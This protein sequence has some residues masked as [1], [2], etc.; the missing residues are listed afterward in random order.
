[1]R[2]RTLVPATSTRARTK[3]LKA[4]K[5]L[6]WLHEKE[7]LYFLSI[8]M[9]RGEAQ[10]RGGGDR[11]HDRQIGLLLDTHAFLW[12]IS[13]DPQLSERAHAVMSNAANTLYLSA[14]SGWE[15]AI[16]SRLGKLDLPKE[17]ES[18]MIEQL[19]PNRIE[20]LSI[21]LRHALHTYRLP[22]LHRDP[23]DRIR[24]AQSHL[25]SLP[26]LTVDPAITQYTVDTVW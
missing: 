2:L 12:W 1:M 10:A 26:I 25:E 17:P 4:A 6:L 20:P 16:K 18:F 23:F 9:A 22:M 15:M 3:G 11:G 8:G 5:C 7:A 14:A 24:I 19:H 21:F 13:D